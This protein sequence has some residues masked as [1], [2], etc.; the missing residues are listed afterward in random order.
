MAKLTDLS[1][2]LDAASREAKKIGGKV[3]VI[4]WKDPEIANYMAINEYGS[5]VSN[6]PARP[7]LRL[8]AK[9]FTTS[10]RTK[11]TGRVKAEEFL[12][13]IA[14]NGVEALQSAFTDNSF[15]RN[16]ERT[17]KNKGFDMPL[18]DTEKA[19]NEIDYEIRDK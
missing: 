5:P 9:R 13:N 12:E 16:A 10:G 11:I 15:R 7:L 1:K 18:V 6:I 14:K 4:G 2:T 3:I 17:I 8:A 19:F